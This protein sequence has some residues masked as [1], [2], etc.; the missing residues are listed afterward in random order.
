MSKRVPS[1]LL[2]ALALSLLGMAE[3]AA[4]T[5]LL[6]EDFE[7]GALDSRI[8]LVSVGSFGAAPGIRSMT[9]F[10]STRAW[11]FGRSVCG[12]NCFDSFVAGL[13]IDF[14]APTFVAQISFSEMELFGNWG[15][16]GAIFVD[17]QLWG[18]THYDYGRLPYNDLV[19]DTSFRTHTFRLD[20]ELTT[21]ELRVRDIT[22]SSEIVLDDL[23]V[24]AVPEAPPQALWLAGL[25]ALGF[26]A[27]AGR[28]DGRP[29]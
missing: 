3:G 17:G 4:A 2:P 8:S 18:S 22:N 29:A 19:A 9:E 11:G 25:A 6:A 1:S 10:G 14:G 5:T 13:R 20:R 28:H 7:D 23:V 12:F 27:R 26:L 15:S 24:S 16:G 21:L